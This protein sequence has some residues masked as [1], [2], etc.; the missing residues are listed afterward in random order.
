M[1][2]ARRTPDRAEKFWSAFGGLSDRLRGLILAGRLD[3]AFELIEELL[4]RLGY[5]FICEVTQEGDDAVLVFTPEGDTD[6]A[7]EIDSLLS[8]RPAI[9]GWRFYGRRQRKP[10]QDAF[11]FVDHIFGIDIRDARFVLDRHLGQW[12]VT[13]YSPALASLGEKDRQGLVRTFLWHALGEDVVMT[14]ISSVEARTEPATRVALLA[15]SELVM[16]LSDA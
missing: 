8:S 7:E 14:R 13:M 16:K 4:G 9:P 10:V 3:S 1:N 11:V 12:K 5:D 2:S 15:P 6:Q